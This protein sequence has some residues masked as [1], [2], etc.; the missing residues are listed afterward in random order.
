MST[1]SKADD[2]RADGSHNSRERRSTIPNTSQADRDYGS[3]SLFEDEFERRPGPIQER[4]RGLQGFA[5]DHSLRIATPTDS[6]YESDQSEFTF[7][8]TPTGAPSRK[9]RWKSFKFS[10]LLSRFQRQSTMPNRPPVPD[11]PRRGA[12]VDVTVR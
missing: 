3:M 2:N 5:E 4:R 8:S 11:S 7:S 6:D 9:D 10:S 1:D 12:Y